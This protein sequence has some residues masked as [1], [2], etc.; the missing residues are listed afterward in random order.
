VSD[1]ISIEKEME[2]FDAL[3]LGIDDEKSK[4]LQEYY[5]DIPYKVW[6]IDE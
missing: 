1:I 3:E 6:Y 5:T 4:E 2:M